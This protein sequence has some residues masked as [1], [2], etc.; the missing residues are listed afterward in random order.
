MSGLSRRLGPIILDLQETGFNGGRA[1]QPPQQVRTSIH[2]R[3][4]SGM[5][6]AKAEFEKQWEGHPVFLALRLISDKS[7]EVKTTMTL[8]ISISGY[9]E[10]NGSGMMLEHA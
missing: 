5:L 4:L 2:P 7:T 3:S 9:R 8:R 10:A 6:R 1:P